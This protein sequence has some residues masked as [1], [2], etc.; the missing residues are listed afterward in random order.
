MRPLRLAA[1]VL[2]ASAICGG[3]GLCGS[4]RAPL[5]VRAWTGMSHVGAGP[6]RDDEAACGPLGGPNVG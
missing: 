2:T 1:P 3:G 6:R 4:V 5:R